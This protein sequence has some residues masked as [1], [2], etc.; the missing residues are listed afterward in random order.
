MILDLLDIS[1]SSQ[2]GGAIPGKH[3]LSRLLGKVV[4]HPINPQPVFLDFQGIEIATASYIRESVFE[5]KTMMR[6]RRST[7]YPVIA[8]ASE[9][10]LD[11]VR[12]IARSMNDVIVTCDLE[13]M[14]VKNVQIVGQL[15]P[16]QKMTFDAVLK[17]KEA[18]ASMLMEQYG[19]QEQTTRTTAW[20]NRLSNLA[21]SGLL[22]EFPRGRS[23]TYRPLFDEVM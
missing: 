11:E 14:V 8:N 7:L 19:N 12:E 13:N 15:D 4:E 6:S 17:I 16:K 3:M 21:M 10:V 20:N 5:F 1:G 18:D 22:R 9:I 23:K 2:L